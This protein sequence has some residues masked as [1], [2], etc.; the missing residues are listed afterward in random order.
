MPLFYHDS[1]QQRMREI[2]VFGC[3]FL[4]L[5]VTFASSDPTQDASYKAGMKL[6]RKA[7]P[8]EALPYFISLNDLYPEIPGI[9]Y[10]LAYCYYHTSD[11]QYKSFDLFEKS[12]KNI[13]KEANLNSDDLTSAPL[14]VY[15]Y[16][17]ML[18]AKLEQ[19]ELAK[20][21]L[22]SYLKVTKIIVEK[23]GPN[24]VSSKQR[25]V[26][27][28]FINRMDDYKLFVKELHPYYVKRLDII[29]KAEISETDPVLFPRKDGKAI[30]SVYDLSMSYRFDSEDTQKMSSLNAEGIDTDKILEG[31]TIVYHDANKDMLILK[32]PDSKGKYDLFYSEKSNERWSNPRRFNVCKR[33]SNE[34]SG[35][36][37]KDGKW[38]IFTSDRKHTL[39]GYDI[40]I[41]ALNTGRGNWQKPVNAGT[42]VNTEYNEI[43]VY[44]S[45]EPSKFYLSSDNPKGVGGYDIYEN[46]FYEGKIGHSNHLKYPVNSAG[47]DIS[48]ASTIGPYQVFASNRGAKDFD[49]YYVDT[50]TPVRMVQLVGNVP[51]E[52]VQK[53]TGAHTD[54]VIFEDLVNVIEKVKNS[55]LKTAVKTIEDMEANKA[56][57]VVAGLELKQAIDIVQTIAPERRNEI[58]DG[59]EVEKAVDIIDA[60]S[61]STAVDVI[62]SMSD[63]KSVKVI[64][65]METSK[66]LDIVNQL[67]LS[68]AVNMLEGMEVEKA[69]DFMDDFTTT[70][71]INMID[72]MSAK[73][74]AAIV[75][76]FEE[77]KAT[78]II[79]GVGVERAVEVLGGIDQEKA[80]RIVDRFKAE[81]ETGAASGETNSKVM[82]IIKTYF[83]DQVKIK[84]SVIFKTVYFDFNSS[85]LLLLTRHELQLLVTFMSEN[86]DI[87][88]E[89]VGHTD[90][91]GDWDVNL[92][93]SHD[94]ANE[95]FRFLRNNQIERERIIFYGKGPASPLASNETDEG[96]QQNRRVEV[97][98]LQ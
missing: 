49:L 81:M 78:E 3:F 36:I 53:P 9:Q 37:S 95:V 1:Y 21:N 98:L 77:N 41:S 67:D 70:K 25:K 6:I 84:E 29:N 22:A 86:K 44:P 87:K 69:V 30:T 54:V 58:L 85:E 80:T 92:K 63:I 12:K 10:R 26:I 57:E 59:M 38:L 39:G 35:F 66:A 55:D 72:K 28:N 27:E 4:S 91:I 7:K 34:T 33:K 71:A 5:Q 96:R 20:T 88:I 45:A 43:S 73:N 13:S 64:E 90:N 82:A 51:D 62:S 40:W 23:G 94:R 47:D 15:Y 11:Q 19:F 46:N 74:A 97:I 83:A 2:L 52:A 17:G 68:K 79:E 32:A 24:L 50:T 60:M 14:D 42:R 93:V 31:Y 61:L 65:E 56:I 16:Q 8:V 75:N 48:F 76:R 89:V 18:A